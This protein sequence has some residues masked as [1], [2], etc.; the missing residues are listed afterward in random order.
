MGGFGVRV[1]VLG[2]GKGNLLCICR[3]Q[4]G[5]FYYPWKG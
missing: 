1:S 5:G 3:T 4:S 2:G